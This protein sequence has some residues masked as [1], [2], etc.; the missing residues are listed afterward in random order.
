MQNWGDIENVKLTIVPNGTNAL[1]LK[2]SV[3][4]KQLDRY[5]ENLFTET[6]P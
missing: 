1:F 6:L 3:Y 4:V 2:V 5:R